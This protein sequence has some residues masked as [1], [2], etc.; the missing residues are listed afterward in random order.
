VISPHPHAC[1]LLSIAALLIGMHVGLSLRSAAQENA[2]LPDLHTS[3][4]I[5]GGTYYQTNTGDRSVR[6]PEY[7]LAKEPSYI[8]DNPLFHGAMYNDL[9]LRVAAGQSI[10]LDLH[11]IAEH[12][13]QSYGVFNTKEMIVFPRALFSIDTSITINSERIVFGGSVGDYSDMRL[14]E[15]LLWDHFDSQG[16]R[17]HVGWRYV[18]LTYNKIADASY[19]IGLNIGD[20]DD[21]ILAVQGIPVYPGLDASASIGPTVFS[22]VRG[23]SMFRSD[24]GNEAWNYALAL[25]Y[26]A[27]ARVYGQYAVRDHVIGDGGAVLVGARI[28]VEHA[29]LSL[30]CTGEFRRYG[31]E[32]NRDFIAQNVLYR[33]P[34]NTIG[35]FLYPLSL[36]ERPFSQWAVYTEYQGLDVRAFVF[37]LEGHL[38]LWHGF[39]IST[40]LDITAVHAGDLP[41][42]TYPFY[43]IGIEWS[44]F[45]GL[46]LLMS[47]T[48]KGM[49]LDKHYPTY[50]LYA[51]SVT[52]LTAHWNFSLVGSSMKKDP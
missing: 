26:G 45:K 28:R 50:Y 10:A 4:G 34:N 25:D 2:F 52:S 40:T 44:P 42:F 32:F 36:L 27:I 21:F 31:A 30:A 1:S 35:E 19:G 43:D 29:D 22:G 48:N 18:S 39:G 6:L 20:A 33:T 15:G 12:R 9:A 23:S 46:R 3:L 8:T 5:N 11:L 51:A 16:S 37:Q 14:H 13:G 24:F 49:N 7:F 17:W 41:S 38:H 47:K